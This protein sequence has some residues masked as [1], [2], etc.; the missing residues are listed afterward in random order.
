MAGSVLEVSLNMGEDKARQRKG[1]ETRRHVY[2][3]DRRMDKWMI[4]RWVNRCMG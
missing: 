3:N 2:L 1:E 4:N